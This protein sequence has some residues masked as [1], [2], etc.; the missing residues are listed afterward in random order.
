[1]AVYAGM[2]AGVDAA[3]FVRLS[4]A[5][6]DAQALGV[7]P[8]DL[9]ELLRGAAH[10]AQAPCALAQV[11]LCP[12]DAHGEISSSRRLGCRGRGVQGTDSIMSST[13]LSRRAAFSSYR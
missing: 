5:V 2:H 10:A 12:S 8:G 9:P 3:L 1:M 4:D 13:V 6:G 11:G 7:G